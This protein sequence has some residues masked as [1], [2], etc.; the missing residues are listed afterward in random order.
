MTIHGSV[1][2]R[3]IAGFEEMVD[4]ALQSKLSPV[5]GTE[6]L[7]NTIGFKLPN[8]LG[9]DD[10]TAAAEYS[11]VT[12]AG[13]IYQIMHVFEK[14]YVAALI[15]ANTN[16]LDILLN[17]GIYNFGYGPVVSKVDHFGPGTL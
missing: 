12:G 2:Y 13:F 6:N 5:F 17:C 16:C 15:A 1:A 3:K 7:G 11:Y 10:S 14:L 9:N 8:F 4:H